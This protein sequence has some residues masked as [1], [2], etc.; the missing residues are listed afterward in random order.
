[1]Q[2]TLLFFRVQRF[3]RFLCGRVIPN[4]RLGMN[5]EFV[6]TF[7]VQSRLSPSRSSPPVVL[8]VL[9]VLVRRLPDTIDL[10]FVHNSA[11]AGWNW[12]RTSSTYAD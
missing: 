1:M 10:L 2:I 11:F 5:V 8:L 3:P 12:Q 7:G 9:E 6:S 4:D